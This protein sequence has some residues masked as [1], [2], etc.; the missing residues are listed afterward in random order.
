[1][2]YLI[3]GN[4]GQLGLEFT[5]YLTSKGE[6]FNGF[7]IQDFDIADRKKVFDCISE[8]LPNVVLNCAAYT[9]VD[10]SEKDYH[11]AFKVNALGIKNI[12]EASAKYGTKV[13][14]FSTDYVFDGTKTSGLYT[15]D[16]ITKP[17]NMY[18]KSKYIGELFLTEEMENYLIFRT[19]WLY[20]KGQ[21]FF[22]KLMDWIATKEHIR[23][24]CDE[25]SVPTWTRTVVEVADQAIQKDMRGRFHLTNTGYASR[26][27][28]AKLIVKLTGINTVLYPVSRD[29]FNM[30]AKRPYFSAMSNYKLAYKLGIEIPTWEDAF[31]EYLKTI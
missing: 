11:S 27:E 21:N 29:D 19:S 12:A 4:R 14:H 25:V 13:V 30:P 17:I 7:D 20:G 18:G 10:G 6:D 24:S 16:D 28:W 1:M 9:D 15:E 5:E 31:K 22:N 8:L 3:L 2:K 23:I 26:Y